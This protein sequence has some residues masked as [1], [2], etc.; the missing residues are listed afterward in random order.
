MWFYHFTEVTYLQAEKCEFFVKQTKGTQTAEGKMETVC[1]SGAR[2]RGK[3]PGRAN[4]HEI[5]DASCQCGDR[6]SQLP[7]S[8]ASPHSSKVVGHR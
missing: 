2:G 4:S 6:P 7:K 8:R 1:P 3:A 5:P